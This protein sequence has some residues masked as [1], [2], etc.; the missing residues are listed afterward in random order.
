LVTID[1]NDFKGLNDRLGHA[2]GDSL[3]EETAKRLV[4]S[5]PIDATVARLGGDE[6]AIILPDLASV[7]AY[8]ASTVALA[9][10]LKA[11]TTIDG[12][13]VPISFCAGVSIWPRDGRD[14]GELLIAADLALY[15]AKGELPGTIK[16]F[17]PSLR[18]ASE[19]R[20]RMLEIARSALDANHILP[21]Y[22]PK[23]D[24][25][26]GRIMGWEALL[27][28]QSADGNILSPA[29]I[30]A[31]F[32]DADI[33][34]KLTDRMLERVFAD[35]AQW[36]ARGIDPGRIAV[37]VSASDFRLQGLASRLQA[38]AQSSGQSLANI[39]IEV[40]EGV[41][42]GQLGPEVSRMLE[43]LRTMG[44]MVALDDFGTGYASLTH[45]Q[46]FPVDVIKIDKS[47]V[48]RL[49]VDD[50][51][52]T[53]VVDAVLQ[54]AKRLNMQTVAEGVETKEQ[55]RYLRARACTIGQGYFF[56]RPIAA[57]A[58]PTLMA[59]QPFESWEFMD[60]RA[61]AEAGVGLRV[62]R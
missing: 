10:N 1:L 21:F 5:V 57:S 55:A 46:Q 22:Q 29:Q 17:V 20:S 56:S 51:K 61:V 28:V 27:R 49:E 36:R 3:L 9:N 52:A 33:S 30:E 58:V 16:E 41:L 35:I 60:D 25:Q 47:F 23:V 31:A 24:L 45:L 32:A 7:D 54:M 43:E 15:A 12:M 4:N 26:N 2:A 53:A 59:S 11:S 6:F 44:V 50:A 38:H 48:D 40:T 19:L 39:D 14:P 34:V 42:I 18:E 8:R 13:R 62:F 37:N